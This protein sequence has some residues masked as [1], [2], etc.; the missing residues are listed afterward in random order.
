MQ[1]N[2]FTLKFD[3]LKL[4]PVFTV[5]VK[6]ELSKNIM[7]LNGVCSYRVLRRPEERMNE[8]VE[9]DT[10]FSSYGDDFPWIAKEND[11]NFY[12]YRAG[13]DETSLVIISEN[14]ENKV[15]VSF[16]I[17]RTERVGIKEGR[18]LNRIF[19]QSVQNC[20]VELSMGGTLIIE[21]ENETVI[22]EW[23]GEKFL[24]R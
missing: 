10:L 4:L 11:G 12:I 23:D 17:N 24:Y 5:G 20:F 3:Q 1:S 21:K 19:T 14:T 7:Y 9:I 8:T 2:F 6:V 16:E 15:Y 13:I 18:V 22:V